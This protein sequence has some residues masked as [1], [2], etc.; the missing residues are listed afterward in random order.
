MTETK[1]QPAPDRLGRDPFGLLRAD[2]I[3]NAALVNGA[4]IS[5]P[6]S[7][8]VFD[9]SSGRLLGTVPDLPRELVE[10]AV[11]AA[12]RALPDWRSRTA[13]ERGLLLRRWCALI[14]AHESDLAR[15]ITI[16]QGKPLAE[17]VGE[18]QSSA[19]YIEWFADEARRAYGDTIP[20]HRADK[21]LTVLKLPVGV[22]AAVTPWNFPSA[23]LARKVGPALAA[24]CTIVVKPSELTP[25]SALAL[26]VLAEEAG[27]PAGVINIVTGAP[28][29]IGEVLTTD[30][31]VR[32]FTFTGSTA[33]GKML[34]ARCMGTVKRVSLELGGNAPFVVFADA[35]LDAAVEAA[36]LVKF[37]NA[38]QTCIS[39]NRI[40][41][42]NSVYDEFAA[43]LQAR[44][45]SLVVGNG[46]DAGTQQGPLINAAAVAKTTRHVGDA[47]ERGARL[48]TGGAP[49]DLPGSYFQPTVLADVEPDSLLCRE[50]TFGPVAPLLRFKGEAQAIA[51]ANATASG[52]SAYFFTRD[53]A[54][55]HRVSEALEAGMVGI[56]SVM[57][58][59]ESA[60]F[61]GVKESGLG[62]E[63][64]RYGLDEY[65]DRRLVSIDVPA[66]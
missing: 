64:S 62:C 7:I 25:F 11:A 43:R 40:L 33:V 22:V 27:I 5:T 41:V 32:K 31:R 16:E 54:R 15:I 13:R 53:L 20:G 35:D 47:L 55:S 2:L 37:R 21:R 51:L 30:P 10:Q 12:S 8:D 19:A 58:A 36:M 48:L 42:E 4:W 57:I 28:A 1:P 60:P 39:A 50:E 9:P 46:L 6:R 52:L 59:T 17:A 24:G 38:G 23:M 18:I 45:A 14:Q 3:R 56:N 66:L 49:A 26:G 65:L 61:G 63:G 34:A 44:A 29:A